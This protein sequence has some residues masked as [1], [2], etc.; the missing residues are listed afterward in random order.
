VSEQPNLINVSPI[1]DK[2]VPKAVQ[3]EIMLA[4]ATLMVIAQQVTQHVTEKHVNEVGAAIISVCIFVL[5][6]GARMGVTPTKNVA[7]DARVGTNMDTEPGE[8]PEGLV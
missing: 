4:A 2:L 6:L 7:L 1:I 5:A 3:Q 8:I